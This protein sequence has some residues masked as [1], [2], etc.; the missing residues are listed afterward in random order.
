MKHYHCS[1]PD[2]KFILK[3][4]NEVIFKNGVYST[5]NKKIIAELDDE[6]EAGNPYITECA[7]PAPTLETVKEKMAETVRDFGNTTATSKIATSADM[8]AAV[9]SNLK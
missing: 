5:E 6:V 4:G 3:T 8:I 1:I 7:A 9:K 2:S